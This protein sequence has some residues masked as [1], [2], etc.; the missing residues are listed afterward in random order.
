MQGTGSKSVT[1]IISSLLHSISLSPRKEGANNNQIEIWRISHRNATE[2]HQE[3]IKDS[4]SPP[5]TIIIEK[6]NID[7]LLP[8]FAD[9]I[10]KETLLADL[11][12]INRKRGIG[13][14]ILIEDEPL[15]FT[16]IYEVLLEAG[17]KPKVI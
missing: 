16:I 5:L 6:R 11:E 13:E 2:Q 1:V 4:I 12:D 7:P 9:V 14:I 15:G 8:L 17:Y 10:F 3:M